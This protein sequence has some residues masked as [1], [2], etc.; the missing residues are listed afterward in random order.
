MEGLGKAVILILYHVDL[1]D[2]GDSSLFIF[3]LTNGRVAF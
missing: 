2:K 3:Q 1:F